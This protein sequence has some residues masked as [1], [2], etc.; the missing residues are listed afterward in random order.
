MVLVVP[1]DHEDEAL[2]AAGEDARVIGRVVAGS[3]LDIR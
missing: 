3:G 2:G 1:G